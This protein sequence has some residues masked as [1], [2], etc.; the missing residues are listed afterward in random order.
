MKFCKFL[1][2]LMDIKQVVIIGAGP[3]GI[4]AAI[5]LKRSGIQPHIFEKNQAGGLLW[6][7]NLVENYPGF[8]EG[9]PGSDL[10]HKMAL[11][12]KHIGVEVIPDEVTNLDVEGDH[13]KITSQ[14]Q[15][16]YCQIVLVASGTKPNQLTS[17]QIPDSA[18]EK[19]YYEVSP[20]LDQR[21]KRIVIVGAGDAAFD[22]ALNLARNNEVILLNRGSVIKSLPL[23]QER[24]FRSP[25]I[26][27]HPNTTLRSIQSEDTHG[28]L[29]ECM[30]PQGSKTFICNDL[31]LAIGREPQMDFI[32]ESV[33]QKRQHLEEAGILYFI[34]D[35]YNKMFRQTTIAVGNGVLAAMKVSHIRNDW[36][37]A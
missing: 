14:Q 26:N 22:Y 21:G 11:H 6:N 3:A 27:Y 5:Q 34:G 16:I 7:A 18:R 2:E 13:F 24:V 20:L 1:V 25:R 23:L 19:V 12:L 9:I 36:R 32:S 8:P 30:S 4:A 17:L 35:A 15:L 31:I 10:A 33:H 28:L 29:L 37:S